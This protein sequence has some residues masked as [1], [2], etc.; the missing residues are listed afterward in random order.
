MLFEVH[1]GV[2]ADVERFPVEDRLVAGLPDADGRLPVGRLLR[3]RIG[4]D[5][6][7]G[8]RVAVDFQPA[9]RQSVRQR[10][11]R[12]QRGLARGGLRRLLG[13]DGGSSFTEVGQRTLQLLIG[14]LLLRQRRRR[15]RQIH[16]R[17]GALRPPRLA[18]IFGVEPTAAERPR[19][20]GL[21]TCRQQHQ[22]DGISEGFY[23]KT[24]M[25]DITGQDFSAHGGRW[26]WTSVGG[27]G[28]HIATLFLCSIG[29]GGLSHVSSARQFCI[30]VVDERATKRVQ[31]LIKDSYEQRPASPCCNKEKR[32]PLI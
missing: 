31:L 1:R 18:D 14:L 22:A 3:R 15:A 23:D 12:R 13:G 5:P 7:L 24:G 6:P 19:F 27:S 29:P 4:I 2:L 9:L 30:Q 17:A 16:S 32:G 21:H 28:L 25:L 26:V 11:A 20:G 8:R 10:T